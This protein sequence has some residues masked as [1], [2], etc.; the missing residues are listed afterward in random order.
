MRSRF[1]PYQKDCDNYIIR[2]INRE[3]YLQFVK[4]S[5]LSPFDSKKF[6][7]SNI[8]SKPWEW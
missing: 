8:R 1:S 6:D 7:E 5:T 2:S 3:T 4:K